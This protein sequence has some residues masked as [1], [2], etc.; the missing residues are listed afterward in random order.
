MEEIEKIKN[1]AKISEAMFVGYLY[2]DMVNFVEYHDKVEEDDFLHKE[3]RFFF[4]LGKYIL[5]QKYKTIDD[6]AI[7]KS[8]TELSWIDKFDEYGGYQTI[9]QVKAL[10][11]DSES[12]TEVYYEDIKRNSTIK[13]LVNLFGVDKIFKKN[14]NYDYSKMNKDEIVAYWQYQVNQISLSM[15]GKYDVQNLITSADE[16]IEEL[17]QA[18][19][20]MLPFTHS[21]Y[22][23][24]AIGG[25][26]ARG[27]VTMVGSYGNNGKSTFLTEK[28]IFSC[29]VHQEP[30]LAIVN[31]ENAGAFRNKLLA[32]VIFHELN[33]WTFDRS[34]F[35]TGDFTDDE[36]DIL[37]KAWNRIHE[38]TEGDNSLI[39]IAFLESYNYKDLENLVKTYHLQGYDNLLVDT[40]KVEDGVTSDRWIAFTEMTKAIYKLTRK[41]AGG[42]NLRTV[43]SLQLSDASIGA[44]FL[45]FS[46]IAEGRASKNEAS[47]F[48]AF[49]NVF[50]DELEGGKNELKC[51]KWVS[52]TEKEEFTLKQG[53]NYMLFFIPKNR[54][55]SN[56]SSTDCPVII[57]EAN[58]RFASFKEVGYCIVPMSS[59]F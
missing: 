3:W 30:L 52:K 54:F 51:W 58:F 38:L 10:V 43:L 16:H 26:T 29:I 56:S 33:E 20:D 42:L 50:H 41:D 1:S 47:V 59:K 17:K 39:K 46:T 34:K 36:L 6:I 40:H 19:E 55:G 28:F 18:V 24:R 7:Q 57:M 21:K 49:R 2:K 11:E 32:V 8:L 9:E 48:I 31:E 37:R 5:G 4:N 44:R 13:K 15:G 22:M 53:K 35:L 25:G 23:N 14:G 12:N 27:H 45:D